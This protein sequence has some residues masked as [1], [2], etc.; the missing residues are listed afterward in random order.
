M[1]VHGILMQ[2]VEEQSRAEKV[3]RLHALDVIHLL[4]MTITL[5]F[6]LAL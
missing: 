1:H 5:Q 4:I 6:K 3:L 2:N